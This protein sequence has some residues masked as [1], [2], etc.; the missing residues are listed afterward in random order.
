MAA[1]TPIHLAA[2]KGNAIFL[3]KVLDRAANHEA[4]SLAENLGLQKTNKTTFVSQLLMERDED[5]STI[6]HLA[7]QQKGSEAILFK[8]L[9]LSKLFYMDLSKLMHGFVKIVTWISQGCSI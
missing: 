6:F 2:E 7:T 8:M 3:Q 1:E 4:G 9:D 5:S